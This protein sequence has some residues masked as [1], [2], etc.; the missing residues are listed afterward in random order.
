MPIW[1]IYCLGWT[2]ERRVGLIIGWKSC[3]FCNFGGC[4]LICHPT[5]CRPQ[6]KKKLFTVHF[7]LDDIF[8][9]IEAEWMSSLESNDF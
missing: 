1:L 3:N 8:L 7:F 2:G 9:Y 5:L 4:H 6:T